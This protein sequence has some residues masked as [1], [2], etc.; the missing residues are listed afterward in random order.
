VAPKNCNTNTGVDSVHGLCPQCAPLQAG[1]AKLR[2]SSSRFIFGDLPFTL[3]SSTDILSVVTGLMTMFG[4]DLDRCRCALVD[5]VRYRIVEAPY[6]LLY[7]GHKCLPC[8]HVLIR[9]LLIVMYIECP[10][11]FGMLQGYRMSLKPGSPT[12]YRQT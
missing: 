8:Q 12:S 2:D 9:A 11:D 1:V 6:S 3:A 10:A 4:H 5:R 7:N